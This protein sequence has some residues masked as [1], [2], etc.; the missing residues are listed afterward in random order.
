MTRSPA[1][2]YGRGSAGHE[3]RDSLLSFSLKTSDFPVTERG[4]VWS[5][6]NSPNFYMRPLDGETHNVDAE[7]AAWTAGDLALLDITFH[8]LAPSGCS[9]SLGNNGS[10]TLALRYCTGGGMPGHIADDAVNLDTGHVC[11]VDQRRD[12]HGVTSGLQQ[13]SIYLPYDLIGYDPSRH[14]AA[15]SYGINT[16]VGGM[17]HSVMTCAFENISDVTSSQSRGFSAGLQGAIRGL[18]S[19]N[20]S[21]EQ[22]RNDFA[23]VR[24]DAMRAFIGKN[25]ANPELGV[26]DVCSAVGVSRATAFRE[27]KSV[28]GIRRYIMAR[29]LDH[30]YQA[31]S[32][33]PEVRGRVSQVAFDSGF[34]D[35]GQF[36]RVFRTRFG[37]PPGEVLGQHAARFG[38]KRSADSRSF[39]SGAFRDREILFEKYIG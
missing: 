14:P 1:K 33:S 12:F 25:F 6:I 37:V 13:I 36:S 34:T 5:D 16:P 3:Q 30:A 24:S 21:D 15:R 22:A 18:L 7:M 38:E 19:A 9:I 8:P 28:G 4:E 27:F 2:A 10:D 35:T 39:C 17:L 29:R 11:L 26:A 20:R 23:R 32:R 31:L